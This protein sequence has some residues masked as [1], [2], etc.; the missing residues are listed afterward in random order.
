[1]IFDPPSFVERNFVVIR[2]ATLF[3]FVSRF[4]PFPKR[5]SR[6]ISV[7]NA[8]SWPAAPRNASIRTATRF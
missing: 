6:S 3:C 7:P 4:N 2:R 1:M 5:R 8:A